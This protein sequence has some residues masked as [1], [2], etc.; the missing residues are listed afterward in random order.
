MT[1]RWEIAEA[2][3]E[4]TPAKLGGLPE[5]IAQVLWNRGVRSAEEAGQFLHP[6]Y[7]RDTHDPFLMANMKK[8]VE[9]IKKALENKEKIVIYGDFDADG[10]C[11]SSLLS[12]ALS[13]LGSANHEVYLPHR[14]R[15]G[16][17][18]NPD[19]VRELI[20]KKTGLVITV[21]CGIV[22]V[23]EVGELEAAGI[24]VIL[25]D[26]H[27]IQ[28]DVPAAFAII[29]HSLAGQD[30]PYRF[31]SGAGV[32]FKL[33]Q[34]LLQDH[35]ES[36]GAQKWLLD[37]VAVATVADMMPLT[38]ENRALVRFGLTV[39][40]KTRR[41]GL[42]ALMAVAGVE[43]QENGVSA[44][45]VGY[46][47]APRINA[48]GRLGSSLP[49][50]DLLTTDD[51]SEAARIA[52]DLSQANSTRQNETAKIIRES[53]AA[54]AE[55]PDALAL[56]LYSP[57]WNIGVVGLAAGKIM[58]SYNRPAIV[59]SDAEG[60]I[61]GSGRSIKGVD[62]MEIMTELE[63][64]YFAR[65]GGHPAACGF[66]LKEGAVLEEFMADFKKAAAERMAGKDLLPRV[67]VDAKTALG[68]IDWPLYES[69][70]DL[71]PFGMENPKPYFLIEDVQIYEK[72]IMGKDKSHIR[73]R[74][75]KDGHEKNIVGFG[76][77]EDFKK[78]DMFNNISVVVEISK[79]VWNGN[80]ELQLIMKDFKAL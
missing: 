65:Y 28:E 4:G 30:Y 11:A 73:L 60:E 80:A 71:G 36:E 27:K 6:D 7:E 19:S 3:P 34:A 68:D 46:R 43:P 72:F 41:P 23:D 59:M 38:G 32:A 76:V 9:R 57:D 78:I 69:L 54:L 10:I 18:L 47:L 8:A 42:R 79:N 22:N 55:D 53:K 66:T 56:A 25:T 63:E 5:P 64:R 2:M 35:P 24:S 74:V 1:K 17:G 31:L 70:L 50:Y 37:L 77:A 51:E 40:A 13:E 15:E 16:Y 61:R 29:H 49:S 44:E 33:A 48:A 26:H 58:N 12:A 75:R 21:D 62:I 39:L 20:E 67:R 45:D 52:E 14:E